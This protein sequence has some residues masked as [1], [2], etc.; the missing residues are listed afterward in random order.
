MFEKERIGEITRQLAE[1]RFRLIQPVTGWEICC[2]A[3]RPAPGNPD[4]SWSSLHGTAVEARRETFTAFSAQVVIPDAFR[5]MAVELALETGKDCL[6]DRSNPQFTVYI[7]GQLRQGFDENHRTLLLT[8]C[9]KG[10]EIFSA[11]LTAFSGVQVLRYEFRPSIRG[12]DRLTEGLYYDLLIPWQI[13]GL[14]EAESEEQQKLQQ[15]CNHAVNMLDLRKPG[16]EPY[17]ASAKQAREYL[18]KELYSGEPEARKHVLCVGHTHIDVAW[19][20]PLR[21]TEDKAVRSFATVLELMKQYPEYKFMSSQPQLYIYVKKNAPEIY[22]QIRQRVAEGRWEVE[23][24]M[25]VEAD[26]NL[27]SG[28]SLVRQCVYGKRFFRQEFGRD[29][30]VLW[31]PDVFGYSAAMPQILEKCGIHYFMTTKISWNEV[32]K[33]PYDTFYWKGIDGTK[34]LTH[35]I[36]TQDYY[37]D[38]PAK[39]THGFSTTYN[40]EMTPSQ[41]KGAWHRYQQKELNPHVLNA[42]GFGDGGGGPT[43]EMLETQRRLHWGLPG[44]PATDMTCS[45]DFFESLAHDL[46]GKTVPIWSGELYLEFHRGTYTSMARNKRANRKGEFALTNLETWAAAAQA[47][48]DVPYPSAAILQGWEVLMRNQFHD[49]LPGSSIREVY[50][51][52]AQEYSRL[53]AL[54]GDGIQCAQQSLADKIGGTVV[55]NSNGQKMSGFVELDG[56]DG[57]RQFQKTENGRFLVWAADVPSKGWKRLEEVQLEFGK[58]NISANRICTPF[59]EIQLNGAGQITSWKDFRA[60][61]ELLAE[62]QCGNV[63]MTYEDKPHSYDNWNIFDYY[64]EKAWPIDRLICAE[65]TER[66]PYR[67]SLRLRWQYLDTVIQETI[68]VYANSPR[69][70]FL[71]ET[72]WKEKQILLKALFPLDI[73][74]TEATY[75]IQYGNVK[76]PTSRNTSWE[77]AKFEVCCHKWMDISEGGFGVAFLNDCKYGV[78]VYENIVGL[79]LLKSGVYPNVNADREPHQ[80]TYSVLPHLESWKEADVVRQAYL[81]NNPLKI[82]RGNGRDAVL[83]AQYSQAFC[84]SRNIMIEVY[85]QAEDRK[86]QILRLYEFENRRTQAR[87]HFPRQYRRIWL[88]NLLEEREA[89]LA[90]KTDTALMEIAPFGIVTLELEL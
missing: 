59:A 30:Q 89:Q 65:V 5:G 85:K 41:I 78:S 26:C 11:F 61:R 87:L 42:F 8:E 38:C 69:V 17:F 64:K 72:D 48:C 10:G 67:G 24:A 84:D 44:C 32:N 81:L 25:F 14:F 88:C 43:V 50:E 73:N 28:E 70:D 3:G 49:I 45:R 75:E 2:T 74:T 23:G 18:E 1:L 37:D 27:T 54:T 19:L 36:P 83:P 57:F 62:G 90:E 20:W 21:V 40:G 56:P 66:G 39:G 31:L 68:R 35:F 34:I 60:D 22:E 33:I 63:L 82:C 58:I 29:N 71:F 4:Y 51:D 76:R 79:S 55:F 7:N 9:A 52:S 6:W 77:Q 47:L 53:F 46:L 86:T 15:V 12:V 80:A 16:T 13:L